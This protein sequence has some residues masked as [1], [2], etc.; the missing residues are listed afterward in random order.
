MT[1]Q[2]AFHPRALPYPLRFT[3]HVLDDVAVRL[4]ESNAHRAAAARRRGQLPGGSLD[5]GH[6]VRVHHAAGDPDPDHPGSW[7]DNEGMRLD[8]IVTHLR[9]QFATTNPALLTALGI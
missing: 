1:K 9:A 5:H 2:R 6:V 3:D 8:S 7:L 4:G